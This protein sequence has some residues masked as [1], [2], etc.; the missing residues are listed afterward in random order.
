MN[1]SDG[2]ANVRGGPSSSYSVKKVLF[3][4][5]SVKATRNIGN[6]F[7]VE[8]TLGGVTY[9]EDQGRPAWVYKS[10]LECNR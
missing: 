10:L 7:S 1:S 6:W 9:G 2:E 4:G 3:N 8:F 5:A